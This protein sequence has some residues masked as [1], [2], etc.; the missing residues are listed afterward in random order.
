VG[1]ARVVRQLESSLE[2]LQVDRFDLSLAHELE[3]DTPPANMVETFQSL[4]DVGLARAWGLTNVTAQEL[5]LI[6]QRAGQPVSRTR[7]PSS[8]AETR[9]A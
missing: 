8:S 2:R 1:R 3:L 7:S 4:A 5:L 9:R 6:L